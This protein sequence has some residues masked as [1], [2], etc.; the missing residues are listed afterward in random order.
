[1]HESVVLSFL[2]APNSALAGFKGLFI[3]AASMGKSFTENAPARKQ[4]IQLSKSEASV[5][6]DDPLHFFHASKLRVGLTVRRAATN[7]TQSKKYYWNSIGKFF[8]WLRRVNKINRAN[9]GSPS[10]SKKQ[11]Y[12]F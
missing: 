2:G 3:A 9:N 12:K 5:S 7:Y 6:T 4:T 10:T 1:V 8:S 11:S